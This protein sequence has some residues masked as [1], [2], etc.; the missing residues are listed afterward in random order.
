M[1]DGYGMV[2]GFSVVDV[3][4]GGLVFSVDP[5]VLSIKSSVVYNECS[6]L[7]NLI[8]DPIETK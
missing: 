6:V 3:Y 7:S 5:S 8:T 2:E 1:V 4:E